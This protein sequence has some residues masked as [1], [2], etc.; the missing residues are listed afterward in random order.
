MK[1][2][3]KINIPLS[4]EDKKL[5][6]DNANRSRQTVSSYVRQKLFEK[7]ELSKQTKLNL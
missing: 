7:T 5:I 4:T 1:F 3:E 6:V 2:K